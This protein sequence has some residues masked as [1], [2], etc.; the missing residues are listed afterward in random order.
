[1]SLSGV[2]GKS[3]SEVEHCLRKY[4]IS[5]SGGLEPKNL[6]HLDKNCSILTEGIN[7]T[8][9]FYPYSFMDWDDASMTLSRVLNCPVFSFHIHDGDFWMFILYK[10]GEVIDQFNPI[11]DYWIEDISTNEIEEQKGNPELIAQLIENVNSEDLSKYLQRWDLESHTYKAYPDDQYV[12]EDWQL[13]DFMKKIGLDFPLDDKDNAK[14]T[15]YQFWTKELE[16]ITD[17]SA[18]KYKEPSISTKPW[19]RLW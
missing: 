7:G 15:V 9:I 5:K 6:N 8:T 1:M 13:V 18:T 16:K 17:G 2:I 14:G 10:N 3:I 12:N 11:P 4:L 19:W